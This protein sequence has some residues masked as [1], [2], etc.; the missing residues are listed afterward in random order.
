MGEVHMNKGRIVEDRGRKEM[1]RCPL[2]S[3]LNVYRNARGECTQ[4]DMLAAEVMAV[5]V[6]EWRNENG[7]C[8]GVG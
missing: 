7:V 8:R 2:T 6:S 4:R 1:D 3:M 5:G